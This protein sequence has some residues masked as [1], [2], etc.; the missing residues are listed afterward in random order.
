MPGSERPRQKRLDWWDRFQTADG[1]V[2]AIARSSVAL[3]IVGGV[4][5]LGANFGTSSVTVFNSLALPLPVEVGD[6]TV[7]AAPFTPVTVEVPQSG[8]VTVRTLTARG[9][10][11][12]TF[13]E[14]LDGANARYVYNV[15]GAV[16]LVEW[17]AVYTSSAFGQQPPKE[18][19][20][21]NLRWSVTH[22][23]HVFEEPPERIQVKENS[24]G[25]R[26]VLT[27]TWQLSPYSQSQS[28]KDEKERTRVIR[29]HARW[30]ATDSAHYYEWLALA[31]AGARLRGNIRDA[32]ERGHVERVAAAL[33]AGRCRG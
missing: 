13:D 33:R 1:V 2:P 27:A 24:A 12:E 22:A 17:T 4:V 31:S 11:I 30:D 19:P 10:L 29:T 26:D 21:G 20:L 16:P 3:G 8:K 28:I 25:Y 5:V 23:D 18:H 15:A 7:R 14:E 6:A 9:E 32:P